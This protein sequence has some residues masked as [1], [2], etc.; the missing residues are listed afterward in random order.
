MNANTTKT[1]ADSALQAKALFA[2][3]KARGAK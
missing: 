1:G 3:E 2:E